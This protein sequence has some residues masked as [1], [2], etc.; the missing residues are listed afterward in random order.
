MNHLVKKIFFCFLK[1]SSFSNQICNT[2][3]IIMPGYSNTVTAI[4][5]CWMVCDLLQRMISERHCS[6]CFN[7]FF[8]HIKQYTGCPPKPFQLSFLQFLS[9]LSTL[10]KYG[11]CFL[12]AH[13]VLCWKM[14]E[15]FDFE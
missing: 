7:K 4:S 8:H 1:L 10:I 14:S 5:M 11:V 6:N 9:F 2:G 3:L 12:S 15:I 13:S